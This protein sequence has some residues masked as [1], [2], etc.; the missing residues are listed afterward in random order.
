MRACSAGAGVCVL[1]LVEV[2]HTANTKALCISSWFS[3]MTDANIS[4]RV[5]RKVV[6]KTRGG[7]YG[8]GG[9]EKQPL[10]LAREGRVRVESVTACLLY[11]LPPAKC[12]EW[13]ECVEVESQ[14]T[15]YQLSI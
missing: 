3:W 13:N 8:V 6:H 7:G 2:L 15:E 14:E 10:P 11:I 12:V 1:G 9:G 4:V 5:Y